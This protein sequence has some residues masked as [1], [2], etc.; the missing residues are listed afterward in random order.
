MSGDLDVALQVFES[1]NVREIA[2]DA[3]IFNTLLDGCVKHN[4]F[5]VHT[6]VD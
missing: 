1:M 5:D 2:A 4:R 6:P 3:I